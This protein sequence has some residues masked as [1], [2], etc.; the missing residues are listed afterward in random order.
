MCPPPPEILPSKLGDP[1]PRRREGRFPRRPHN[2]SDLP[3]LLRRRDLRLPSSHAAAAHFRRHPR[4]AAGPRP[5]NIFFSLCVLAA[6]RDLLLLKITTGLLRLCGERQPIV[7]F[8]A[9]CSLLRSH[10]RIFFSFNATP[11]EFEGYGHP[12]LRHRGGKGIVL[13][14]VRRGLASGKA[15]VGA[16][17]HRP[18]VPVGVRRVGGQGSARPRRR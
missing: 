7:L 3:H 6:Q 17:G 8:G 9:T 1:Q 2:V 12:I 18:P 5:E 11:P 14:V 10:A 16:G 15:S 13:A 4:L